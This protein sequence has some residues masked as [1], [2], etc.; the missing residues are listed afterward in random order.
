MTERGASRTARETARGA[1][2]TPRHAHED[3]GRGAESAG[4]GAES[5]GRG[6]DLSHI[7]GV[8]PVRSLSDGK[9]R[10]GEPLDPEE[11][12]S[13]VLGL[14][15]RTI[16]AAL[17]AKEIAGVT[18]VSMDGAL[19]DEARRL[20]ATALMQ[21]WAGLN[22]GL[23][24][25]RTA[26]TGEATALLVV[27][28][29]LPEISASSIDEIVGA[30]RRAAR[31]T[32]SCP[33]V[34][35]VPDR[36]GTGTNALLISP[37]GAIDFRFGPGSLAAHEEAARRAGAS[38]VKLSGPLTFDVDTAEDLLLADLRGLGHEAGR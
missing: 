33:V 5:A 3:A 1:R 6:A 35:L 12:E 34:V 15:R 21:S 22:E 28:A 19:L 24:E 10:L 37:P 11:R 27:S 20:G 13:L 29:D 23:A 36:H 18:V 25:A 14:L 4:R 38:L 32:P 2:E 16:R 26:L 8:I 9:S 7:V 30:G 31:A 17:E